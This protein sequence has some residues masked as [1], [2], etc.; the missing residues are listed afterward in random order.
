MRLFGAI[1]LD[2]YRELN[3]KKLFW[4]ILAMS[5]MVVLTFGSFGFHEDGMSM[6]YGLKTIESDY[7]TKDSIV[8]RVLYRSIFT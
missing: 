7:L 8:S 3:S 4:V 1:L 6:F 5:G 2:A